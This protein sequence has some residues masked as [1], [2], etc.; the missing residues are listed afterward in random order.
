MT[1]F[2]V[3]ATGLT[4]GA[5]ADLDSVFVDAVGDDPGIHDGD[6]AFVTVLGG[7]VYHY[8]ADDDSGLTADGI[9]VIIPL[10]QS[11]GVAYIG[12]LRWILHGGYEDE[13]TLHPKATSSGAEGTIFYCN[14]DDHVYVGTE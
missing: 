2:A 11:L 14:L 10:W 1:T 4:G 6:P 5:D 7:K 12:T 3:G 13:I 8:I 9:K